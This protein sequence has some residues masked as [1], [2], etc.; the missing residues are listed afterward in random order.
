MPPPMPAALTSFVPS[1]AALSLAVE[2][3]LTG[4]EGPFALRV[5]LEIAQGDFVVLTGPSGAGKTTLLRLIAGLAQPARGRVALAGQVWCDTAQGINL[6]VRCRP[7]GFVFQDYALFPN[8]TAAQQIAFALPDL[9]APARAA[10]VA[11]LLQLAGLSALAGAYPARLSGGQKQRLALVRALARRPG[12]LL[13]DEPLS[14][15][16][17][18]TRARLQTDLRR[19]H[20]HFGATTVMTS[21]DPAEAARLADRVL[22]LD[23]G[24][25]V[26]PA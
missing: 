23:A 7:I 11:E 14:A 6:P 22:R 21:H 13:L 5:A 9:A 10:R 15:L 19:M 8:M 17:P 25:L 26:P 18:E 1:A 2:A 3:P 12:L 24:Q 16:D 20:D 4:P